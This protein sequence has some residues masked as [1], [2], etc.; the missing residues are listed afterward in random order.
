VEVLEVQLKIFCRSLPLVFILLSG[1]L[2]AGSVSLAWIAN[3]ENDLA[4]YRV[5]RTQSPGTGYSPVNT[6]L[7]TTPAFTDT[8]VVA[9]NTYYYAV[10][11]V[12][13][14]GQESPKSSEVKAILPLSGGN[15]L[16]FPAHTAG[17]DP[18]LESTFVGVAVL[19]TAASDNLVQINSVDSSGAEQ[20]ASSSVFGPNVQ[21]A[22]LAASLP[23][24]GPGVVAFKA[25]GAQEGLRSF[26]LV[27]DGQPDRLDGV[28][29]KLPAASSLFFPIAA[30][31]TGG[32]TVLFLTNPSN[33]QGADVSLS[34]VDA[35]GQPIQTASLNLAAGASRLAALTDLLTVP[36]LG[37]DYYVRLNAN[38]SIQG[39]ELLAD[40][41]EFWSASAQASVPTSGLWIPHFVL[42]PNGEDTEIRLI[43]VETQPLS[44]RL[45]IYDDSATLLTTK[46]LTVPAGGMLVDRL[47]SLLG[48]AAV[49]PQQPFLTGHMVIDIVA[50]ASVGVSLLGT[51][52][53]TGPL[54]KA[55]STLPM[56]RQPQAD[57]L[58]LHV[59][60]SSAQDVFTGLA[61][62]N[63]NST[64]VSVIVRAYGKDGMMTGERTLQIEAGQRVVDLLNGSRLF[65]PAFEQTGGHLT[66]SGN[67]PIVSFVVFGDSHSRYLSAVEGQ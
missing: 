6:S 12:N 47:S 40:A 45:K 41:N 16:V 48:L 15:A 55:R 10:T 7:V 65:G 63:P 46:D 64:A 2:I 42:G 9:G 29:G 35:Q 61:I 51:A 56:W 26:F 38:N 8:N 53:F 11:A 13:S 67:Q 62:M 19:N 49:P 24:N 60:Q 36:R 20:L 30:E 32:K 59:A 21:N 22:F 39:F 4:G 14:S 23:G 3:A 58:Y 66:V 37:G 57:S 1:Q 5:Y 44:A 54:G 28:G 50:P 43:N 27:G 52:T 25:K 34:L 18:A 33:N 31:T 17:I